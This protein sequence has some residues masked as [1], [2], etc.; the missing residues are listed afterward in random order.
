MI[1]PK[2]FFSRCKPYGYDAVEVALESKRL[3][4]GYCM[5]KR[6]AVY[7]R[8]GLKSCIVDVTCDDA[9]WASNRAASD[10]N[11]QYNR[12]RNF[13]REI[14]AGSIALVPRP[15]SGVIYCGFVRGGFELVD[16]PAWYDT[17]E[18]IWKANDSRDPEDFWIAG[19]VAQTWRVDEFRA[20]PV[21]RI[22]VWIRR[23]LFGRS[24]YGIVRPYGGLD[25]V[26]TL[27]DI[28][29]S[30]SFIPRTWTIDPAEVE[31]RLITDVTPSSF[32]HLVVSLLQLENPDEFWTHVGGSG[33]G[34]LDGIGA[35][36]SGKVVGLLQCK[37]AYWGEEP[38]LNTQ[39]AAGTA[40]PRQILASACHNDGQEAP[41]GFDF[42][43]KKRVAAL[44]VKHAAGLPQAKALRIGPRP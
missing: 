6:D 1:T 24:T 3:F 4:F 28:L 2:V 36:A 8:R 40:R 29:A 26:E 39:W 17:W 33:D 13:V 42:L 23:S 19:E 44:L 9:T 35:D 27:K 37:W 11:R 22:P 7:D 34:G 15:S 16:D 32:E 31:Q 41:T 38:D 5:A 43:D 25:P 20:I 14:G 30:D 10:G 12:N 18:R 21:P